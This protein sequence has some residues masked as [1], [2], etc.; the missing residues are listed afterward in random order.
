MQTCVN[1][2]CIA[3][4]TGYLPWLHWSSQSSL[5]KLCRAAPA[6][7]RS[8]TYLLYRGIPKHVITICAL[9]KYEL[10]YTFLSQIL[11]AYVNFK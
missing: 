3:D 7:P 2:S 1:V 4:R 5:S 8:N 9:L 10:F 11:C 6:S